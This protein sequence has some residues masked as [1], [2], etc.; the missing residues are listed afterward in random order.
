MSLSDY[1][2][3]LVTGA[4]SGIGAAVVRA[5]AARKLRVHAVARRADRL[6]ALARECGCVT[7]QVDLRAGADVQ[8]ALS[9]LDVDIVVNC[10]G[11]GFGFEGLAKASPDEIETTLDTNILG[12]ARV[13]R[14]VLPGMIARKRGHVVNI[15]SIFGRHVAERTIYGA[16]KAAVHLLSQ[17]LRM[18]LRGSGIRV[19]EVSPGRTK[20]E[21]HTV[22]TGQPLADL[23]DRFYGFEVLTAE[24]VADAVLYVLD[25]PWRVN[26]SLLELTATEQTPGGTSIVVAERP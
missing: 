8:A 19:S 12:V 4:S 9:D 13:L 17:N 10:A 11:V 23:E 21:F 1:R 14:A 5:L 15:G 3:A 25:T 22:A 18:E 2:S 6:Q 20:T 7:H 26:V 16:S 24:D